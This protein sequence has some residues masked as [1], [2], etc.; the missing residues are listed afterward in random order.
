MTVG[1]IAGAPVRRHR[2][3]LISSAFALLAFLGFGLTPARVDAAPIT[4][5]FG[6]AE[7]GAGCDVFGSSAVEF[8]YRQ[9]APFSPYSL[10]LDFDQVNGPFS[11][12]ID[13]VPMTQAEYQSRGPGVCVPIKDGFTTCVDFYVT[14]PDPGPRTWQGNYF[15]T[16]LWDPNTNGSY[17]DEGGRIRLLHNSGDVPGEQYDSDITIRGSYCP[18]NCSPFGPG[19]GEGGGDGEGN[20]EFLVHNSLTDPAISGLDDNFQSFTVAQVPAQVPEAATLLLL[21]GGLAAFYRRR[22]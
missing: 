15:M 11:V 5:G 19:D 3:L 8:D 14:A 12:T 6:G 16:I 17:P 18:A 2:S 13:D 22:R 7:S 9:V 1:M 4:C 10:F 21:G 20:I